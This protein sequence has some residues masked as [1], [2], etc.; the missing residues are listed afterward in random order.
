MEP[1]VDYRKYAWIMG[2]LALAGIFFASLAFGVS[3][4][5]SLKRPNGQTASITVS[6]EGEV[7]A[8]PDIATVNITIRES[9]KT[10]P[11]A[12]KL[13]EAKIN[14]AIKA[15]SSLGVED[16]DQKTLSYYVNP[17]YEN[18]PVSSGVSSAMYYP[19]S[20]QK[21]VGYEVTQTVEIKVRK[22]DSAGEVI[23]VL[24]SVNITEMYGPSFTVDDIDKL[25]AEAKE[26]AIAQAR[27]KAKATARALGTNLGEVLQ[28]SEDGNGYYPTY[29]RD[30][31]MNQSYGKGGAESTPATLPQGENVIKSRVTITYSLD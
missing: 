12:Q 23:G 3:E 31:M 9:A 29:A 25:Q 21:I 24:G 17:K 19:I 1:S 15:L 18:V 7:T 14:A 11:E 2:T 26:K 4:W 5:K 10:V 13:V 20:N 28:F 8:V 22:V 27:E 16:K 30:A 6:G